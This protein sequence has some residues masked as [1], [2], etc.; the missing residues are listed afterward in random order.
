VAVEFVGVPQ[1]VDQAVKS[2]R[3]GG[4]VVVAGMGPEKL[5]LVAPNVFTWS[6]YQLSGSFGSSGDDIER[7]LALLASGRLDLSRS[8]SATLPLEEA[9]R[10]L[11]ILQSREGN[12]VR[13][14]IEPKKQPA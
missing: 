8:V 12:P 6:E 10:G 5:Q 14:V 11:E 2:L 4:R 7:V 3:R 13:I 1:T 9:N